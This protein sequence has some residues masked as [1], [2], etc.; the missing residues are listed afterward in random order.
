LFLSLR[1]FSFLS[2][3]LF[4][5]GCVSIFGWD[6]HAPGILSESFYQ[7]VQSLPDRV[8]LYLEPEVLTYQ[9]KDRGGRTADPQTY[10]VGEALAPMLLE[11]FQSAFEEVVFL[12]IEPTSAILKRYGISHLISVRIKDFNNEVSWTGQGIQL[13]TE[14]VVLDQDLNTI[15]RFESTGSS[16]TKKVFAKKGGPQVNLN[17]AIENNVLAIVQSVQDFLRKTP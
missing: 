13:T 5:A 8:G 17:A 9:S 3:I 4:C 12:E 6:I 11:G 16:D 14:A 15:E 2:L 1:A 10:H 7:S